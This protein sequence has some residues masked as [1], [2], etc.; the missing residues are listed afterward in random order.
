MIIAPA[1]A[2]SALPES[3][4]LLL[5]RHIALYHYFRKR[6]HYAKADFH[7]AKAQAASVLLQSL[8]F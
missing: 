7:Y 8:G 2:P 3:L 5:D 4:D 6:G 1:S